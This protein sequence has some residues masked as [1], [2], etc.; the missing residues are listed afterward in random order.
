[1]IFILKN[2]LLAFIGVSGGVAVAAG[3]FA[4]ISILGI[5]PRLAAVL[6]EAAY[7]YQME[8]V[9]LLGGVTGS[10]LT[11]YQVPLAGGNL[12]LGIF[13][14]FSGIFVGCLSM[15]LAETLKVFPVLVSRTKLKTGLPV[16]ILAMAVGKA[17]GT[18]YQLYWK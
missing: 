3:V 2:S 7:V 17:L 4:F 12:V 16:L 1:M 8:T 11:L 15:A 5:I 6:K 14:L 18:L 10:I 9:I 13:G